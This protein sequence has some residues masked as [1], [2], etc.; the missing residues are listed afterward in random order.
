M[1]SYPSYQKKHE[2]RTINVIIKDK[3]YEEITMSIDLSGDIS[4]RVESPDLYLQ[5]WA[6]KNGNPYIVR[7][8]HV[9][10]SQ[11][12]IH[13][14]FSWISTKDFRIIK[15]ELMR[16]IDSDSLFE[17]S[18][19][20]IQLAD[21]LLYP[22]IQDIVQSFF[23]D[24]LS[25]TLLKDTSTLKKM[26]LFTDEN[27]CIA[28]AIWKFMFS[29]KEKRKMWSLSKHINISDRYYTCFLES[30]SLEELIVNINIKRKN[31]VSR[32]KTQY[33]C[34]PDKLWEKIK[35]AEN[36][37]TCANISHYKMQEYEQNLHNLWTEAD[38]FVS[39]YNRK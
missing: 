38:R 20:L 29:T 27:N 3:G 34:L 32:Y 6:P 17:L 36:I 25:K 7:A 5:T 23:N 26:K 39:L 30:E 31:I 24:Y 4:D 2:A 21:S 16:H 28:S 33:D 15:N 12:I 19:S 37:I 18:S 8:K 14:L 35:A 22:Q 1:S 9:E 10:S 11:K 13:L